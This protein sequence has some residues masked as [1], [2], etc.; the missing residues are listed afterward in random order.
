MPPPNAEAAI[1][2]PDPE[3]FA[4]LYEYD[5]IIARNDQQAIQELNQLI[6]V[7]KTVQPAAVAAVQQYHDRLITLPNGP[8]GPASAQQMAQLHVLFPTNFPVTN[9]L[10]MISTGG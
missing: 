9:L 3:A 10:A 1:N 2:P 8:G 5:L 4:V 6:T 7:L